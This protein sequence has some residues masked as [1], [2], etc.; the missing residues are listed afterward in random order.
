L[1]LSES[2]HVEGPIL[3]LIAVFHSRGIRFFHSKPFI[4][5]RD[6]IS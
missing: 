6:L 2:F 3:G 4:T 1:G 5:L